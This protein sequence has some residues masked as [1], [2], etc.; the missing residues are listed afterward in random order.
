MAETEAPAGLW[1]DL[2]SPDP[3]TRMD[4]LRFL[5]EVKKDR[6]LVGVLLDVAQRD[7][8]PAV[9]ALAGQLVEKFK[10]D[11]SG[12]IQLPSQRP[13]PPSPGSPDLRPLAE[14]IARGE[15][16]GQGPGPFPFQGPGPSPGG[17]SGG[18]PGQSGSSPG[19]PGSG[20]LGTSTGLGPGPLPAVRT[21]GLEEILA[22]PDTVRKIEAVRKA[23]AAKDPSAASPIRRALANES[24]PWV[25]ATL[26]KALGVLGDT[27]DLNLV[28][29]FL[30][31]QDLRIQ[32]NAIESL[33]LL[34][35]ELAFPLVSPMLQAQDP[36]IRA[37][38]IRCLMKVDPEEAFSTLKRM[39]LGDSL[40]SR[41][42]ALYCL[43][44]VQHP[45]IPA[46]LVDMLARESEDRLKEK[47]VA[48]LAEEG[49][50]EAIGA[51]AWVRDSSKGLLAEAAREAVARCRERAAIP[52][53]EVLQRKLAFESE[54]GLA[55]AGVGG[56]VAFPTDDDGPDLPPLK[57]SQVPNPGTSMGMAPGQGPEPEGNPRASV[58]GG[59]ALRPGKRRKEEETLPAAAS[60]GSAA[61]G[62]IKENP[63][64][65]ALSG[66]TGLFVMGGLFALGSGID[67]V[68]TPV[69][70]PS[71]AP[72]QVA[73]PTPGPSSPG[74]GPAKPE[75]EE[76]QG[77]T[78]SFECVVDHVDRRRKTAL[79]KRDNQL[80]LALFDAPPPEEIK[81]NDQVSIRGW[82]TGKVRFGAKYLKA[83]EM[84]KVGD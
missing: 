81:K 76:P 71:R 38:A 48:L 74:E 21:P 19:G 27:G 57:G 40:T 63:G 54:R 4:A 65:V 13:G 43:G 68:T 62:F 50:A 37:N 39:A 78:V 20:L 30:K 46:V 36:R 49:G 31:H 80:I 59:M 61:L 47:Q 12:P 5:A 51:L 24:D 53:S 11:V 7:Q 15:A 2:N 72:I 55:P 44:L 29:P 67:Q 82:Y 66:V 23:A 8:D 70:N 45:G 34:G 77:D 58:P 6:K 41:E 10:D 60:P 42:S 3:A 64:F 79:L 26:L 83:Q 14:R 33:E 1:E 25:L 32:A 17:S 18:S 52:E 28:Q 73:R 84:R 69:A 35:D 22:M 75:A 56:V 16:Q 9:R